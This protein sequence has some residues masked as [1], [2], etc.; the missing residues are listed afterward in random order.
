MDCQQRF[1][2]PQFQR[3]EIPHYERLIKQLEQLRKFLLI[4]CTY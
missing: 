2:I 4:H 3:N 1:K